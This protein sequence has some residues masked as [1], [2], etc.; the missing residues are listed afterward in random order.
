MNIYSSAG[1]MEAEGALNI[2]KAIGGDTLV[3]VHHND[4]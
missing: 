4:H 2:W 1:S 3:A